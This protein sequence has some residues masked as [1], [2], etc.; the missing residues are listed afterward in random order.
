MMMTECI[1]IELSQKTIALADKFAK[2]QTDPDKAKQ[3]Y[4]NTIAVKVVNSYLRWMEFE[5]DLEASE[6]WN[7]L[8]QLFNNSADLVLKNIGSLEC[9]PI[10]AGQQEISLPIEARE[11]RIGCLLVK[12]EEDNRSIQI[13]GGFLADQKG[14]LPE[15]IKV[16][17]LIST[18]EFVEELDTLEPLESPTPQPIAQVNLGQWLKGIFEEGWQKGSEL[19][20]SQQ[21]SV[22]WGSGEKT[23]S[24][25]LEKIEGYKEINI[26]TDLISCSVVLKVLFR[27]ENQQSW[28]VQIRVSPAGGEEYLP[29]GLELQVLD[30]EEVIARSIARSNDN[31]IQR[32]IKAEPR[33]E[34]ATKIVYRQAEV[35]NL[36][37]IP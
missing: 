22:A 2:K 15:T 37:T 6:S 35:K 20:Q 36:F 30:G 3:V 29:P 16:A 27:R 33:D 17:E 7:P 5:T 26:Q 24:D 25:E 23:E 10:L 28:K 11:N 13:I 19:F 4:Y 21:L 31:W 9:R 8:T 18:E 14:N 34:F 1:P 12:M 32:N